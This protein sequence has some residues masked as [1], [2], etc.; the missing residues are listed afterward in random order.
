[1]SIKGSMQ[2]LFHKNDEITLSRFM[3]KDAHIFY[4][5]IKSI[6]Y[7][8]SENSRYGFLKFKE[9]DGNSEYF[10]FKRKSNSKVSKLINFI[11]KKNENIEFNETL[12]KF[13][14]ND[15]FN[16]LPA[17]VKFGYFSLC[18]LVIFISVFFMMSDF[19]ETYQAGITLEKYNRCKTG[20]SYEEIVKIIGVDGEPLAETEI[21]G[22]NS[23]AYT[24][25][26]NDITGANATMYFTDN[27]LT[28]KAQIGLE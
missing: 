15:R 19:S 2:E 11:K 12:Q 6:D 16:L 8:F 10:I 18:F 25:Y 9:N 22:I 7:Q 21:M 1:M 23:S 24:W 28:S 4:S 17:K 13:T 20:M 14:L 3:E 26:A 27:K 5:D